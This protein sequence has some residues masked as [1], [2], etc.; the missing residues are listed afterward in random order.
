M[1]RKYL[2]FEK[3][4]MLKLRYILNINVIS[5]LFSYIIINRL[6][7]INNSQNLIP[8]VQKFFLTF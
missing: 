7:I 4:L 3:E 1:I 6:K 5:L 2:K 8:K